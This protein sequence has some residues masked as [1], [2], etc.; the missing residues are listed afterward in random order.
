MPDV[1]RLDRNGVVVAIDTVADDD[2]KTCPTALT[3]ALPAHHDVH[4]MIG[5]YRWDFLRGSFLPLSL[6]PLEVAE[7]DTPG[8]VEGLVA[9]VEAC[10]RQHGIPL[11]PATRRAISAW[12]ATVDGPR[13]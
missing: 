3:V 9:F 5:G 11:P 2:H 1:A 6:E 8:L 12:R 10:E 4:G 13:R 7:R